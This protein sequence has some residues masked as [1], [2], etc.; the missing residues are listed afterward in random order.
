MA[1]PPAARGAP[2]GLKCTLEEAGPNASA[3]APRHRAPA[4]RSRR[5][6][7]FQELPLRDVDGESVHVHC[8][9][10]CAA[11]VHMLS[12]CAHA[13]QRCSL[14]DTS[15]AHEDWNREAAGNEIATRCQS[16]DEPSGL[17]D[18]GTASGTRPS[19]CASAE[20]ALQQLCLKRPTWT[21]TVDRLTQYICADQN[22]D[23]Q[24]TDSLWVKRREHG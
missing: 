6:L 4:R 13:Q 11:C 22:C 16:K 17:T 5:W 24:C 3:R 20:S 15:Q 14:G 12:T 21:C 18:F 7:L 10:L 1:H 23:A 2:R 9:A 19:Y 8:L